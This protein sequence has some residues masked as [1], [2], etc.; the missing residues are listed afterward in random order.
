MSKVF[1]I[2]QIVEH[3]ITIRADSEEA[4]HTYEEEMGDDDFTN[5][6]WGHVTIEELEDDFGLKVDVD[7][8]TK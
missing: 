7:I 2:K 5:M 4:A 1:Q 8:S 6:D 3:T